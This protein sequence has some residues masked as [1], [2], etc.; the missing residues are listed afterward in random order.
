MSGIGI[1][2]QYVPNANA[3]A[4]RVLAVPLA[5]DSIDEQ[6]SRLEDLAG[7]L[8]GR[9]GPL[10]SP[11]PSGT[12]APPVTKGLCEFACVL[13]GKA[14]RIREVADRIGYTLTGLEF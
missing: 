8:I 11:V 1:G 2:G 6:L 3:A 5:V 7:R 12:N 13:E 10:S 14:D 9:I 4:A